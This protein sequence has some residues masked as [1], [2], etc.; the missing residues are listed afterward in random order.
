MAKWIEV[1]KEINPSPNGKRW[2]EGLKICVADEVADK[3]VAEGNAKLLNSA[4]DP[5]V[6]EI[7][8]K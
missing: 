7:K 5:F 6:K 3:L 1:I 4:P 8:K 2:A